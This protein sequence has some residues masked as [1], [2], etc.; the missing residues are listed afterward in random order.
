MLCYAI[1][2]YIIFYYTILYY[3]ILCYTILYYAMLCYT[4]LCYA[5]LYYTILSTSINC[6][7]RQGPP[8]EH[9]FSFLCSICC[10]LI[11]NRDFGWKLQLFPIFRMGDA[12]ECFFVRYAEMEVSFSTADWVVSLGVGVEIPR[13]GEKLGRNLFRLHMS[14][15]SDVGVSKNRGIT[16]MDGL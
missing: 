10:M 7:V 9:V 14:I 1:L 2:C 13:M 4:M 6:K 12:S 8:P 5:M 15:S 16:K 3:A 11:T